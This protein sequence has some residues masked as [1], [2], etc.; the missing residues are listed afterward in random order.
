MSSHQHHHHHHHGVADETI[1]SRSMD[2]RLTFSIALNGVIVIAEVVGG[3]LSGS[4]SLLSDAL[5]NLT[6]V[7]AMT[8][9]LV[10]R[11][12]GRRPPS[13]RHTYGLGRIEVLSALANGAAILVVGT[14]VCREAVLRLLHPQPVAAGLMLVVAS[15]GL[16]AN[17]A[18]VFLLKS[19]GHDD[20]NMRGA[21]LHLLQDTL[22]SVVV[23]LA[24][25]FSGWRYG[26]FL[27]PVASVLVIVMIVRSSWVLL[28]QALQVLL[29]STPAGLDL[30]AL[31]KDIQEQVPGS[32]LH[33]VHVWEIR[34]GR[35]MMTAHIRISDRPLSEV[36]LVL[37]RV[38]ARLKTQWKIAHAVLEPEVEGCGSDAL[39]GSAAPAGEGN[40]S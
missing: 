25:L 8:L 7:A 29:E 12:L 30:K 40:K 3:V 31:R 1:T 32:G 37:K 2:R 17:L 26:A 38:H 10:A 27:D 4:L 21:F 33:H 24:A 14:L 35:R 28:N 19:H 34:P 11:R 20:L 39:L 9:A 18:S 16:V 13:A 22:S 5:H 36:D 15:I 6:D 23:V